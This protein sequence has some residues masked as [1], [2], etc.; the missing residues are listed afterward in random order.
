MN[1]RLTDLLTGH[2]KPG[3][4]RLT[5]QT[6][7]GEI[8]HTAARHGWRFAQLDGRQITS[9]A[10]FLESC[11]GAL[12]FPKHFGN[13][14]DALADSVRDLSW[15]PA[16]HGY[17]VLYDNASVFAAACPADFAVALDIL[18]SAVASW[19]ETSTPMTVL[20]RRAGRAT[21]LIPRL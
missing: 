4:Y 8:A 2:V 3:I 5:Q 19:R 14:W 7:V 9:K 13:N 15:A 17:L 12:D 1:D 21:A 11:A 20:L 16:E 6:G 10:A 18:R